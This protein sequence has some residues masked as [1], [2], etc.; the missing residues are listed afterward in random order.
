MDYI[1]VFK[2]G[3]LCEIVGVHCSFALSEIVIMG[4]EFDTY[5]PTEI[6]ITEDGVHFL[7]PIFHAPEFLNGGLSNGSWYD[8]K[9]LHHESA[10]ET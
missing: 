7:K 1:E 9:H 2:D 4:N 10:K 8:F 5:Q 3:D 6:G